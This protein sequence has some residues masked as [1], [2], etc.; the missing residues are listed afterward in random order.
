MK[1]PQRSRGFRAFRVCR[2]ITNEARAARKAGLSGV[3]DS[4][5]SAQTEQNGY[6]GSGM[7]AA[8]N[9]GCPRPADSRAGGV[10]ELANAI[11][12]PRVGIQSAIVW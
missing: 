10:R 2:L 9:G 12:P 8:R 5:V 7:A 11:A 4:L 6:P 1:E 3:P